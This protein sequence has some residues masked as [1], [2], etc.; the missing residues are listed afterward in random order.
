M[1]ARLGPRNEKIGPFLKERMRLSEQGTNSFQK[2]NGLSHRI[3]YQIGLECEIKGEAQSHQQALSG[4][5]REPFHMLILINFSVEAVE[6]VLS[7]LMQGSTH[8]MP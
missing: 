1:K 5:C 8:N 3:Q 7:H 2:R 4:A 6:I